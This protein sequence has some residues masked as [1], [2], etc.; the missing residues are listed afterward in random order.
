[1]NVDILESN[2][3]WWL[4][5]PLAG[6]TIVLTM[7]EWMIFKRDSQ[8]IYPHV[9]LRPHSLIDPVSSKTGLNAASS[10]YLLGKRWPTKNHCRSGM[11]LAK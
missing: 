5:I 2:P 10:P 6:G 4:Y 1:M 3:P 7:T 9:R 8:V 11:I